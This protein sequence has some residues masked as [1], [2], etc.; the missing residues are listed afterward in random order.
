MKA[1]I[2]N[3]KEGF[4]FPEDMELL[5]SYLNEHG[6]LM[7]E[8]PTLEKMYEGFSDDRYCAQWMDINEDILEEFAE[9]LSEIEV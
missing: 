7:I 4:M 6:K 2:P 5:L 1:Y 3:K 9:W 8:P